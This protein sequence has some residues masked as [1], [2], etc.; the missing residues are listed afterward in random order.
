MV[1][2]ASLLQSKIVIFGCYIH[3]IE[4][5]LLQ[6]LLLVSQVCEIFKPRQSVIGFANGN[7][8]KRSYIDPDTQTCTYS[9]LSFIVDLD[10][11]ELAPRL[12]L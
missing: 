4:Q 1:D 7:L 10:I 3:V 12:V 8:T 11:E 6:P 9:L 2:H 5:S